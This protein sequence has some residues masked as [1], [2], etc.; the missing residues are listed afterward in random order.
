MVMTK[1]L[2]KSEDNVA[3]VEFIHNNIKY[4]MVYPDGW[5]NSM[6]PTKLISF[7]DKIDIVYSVIKSN[8]NSCQ[9]S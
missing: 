3:C 5:E 9:V 6:L 7:S 1:E 4:N 2:I 8:I